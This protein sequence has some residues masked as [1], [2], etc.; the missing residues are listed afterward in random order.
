M[1]SEPLSGREREAWRAVL[2]LADTLRGLVSGAVAPATGLSSADYL[3]LNRLSDAP[4]NR[5]SGLKAL[6]AKLNWSASRLSHQLKR[7]GSRGLV[8]RVYEEGTGQL[9]MTATPLAEQTM[10]VATALHNEA[11]RR[12][13][14]SVATD[15]ELQVII[16]VAARISAQRTAQDEKF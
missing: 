1:T 8:E 16:D 12:Y 13:F 5:L 3:V 9:T 7:M 4:E 15:E 10:R 2:V 14:L 6:A 11:V